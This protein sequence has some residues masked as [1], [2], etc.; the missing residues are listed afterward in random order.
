MGQGSHQSGQSSGGLLTSDNF[1]GTR[2]PVPEHELEEAQRTVEDAIA[3]QIRGAQSPHD[4]R[5]LG[6]VCYGLAME[7]DGAAERY[8][9]LQLAKDS[10]VDAGDCTRAMLAFDAIESRFDI[11]LFDERVSTVTKLVPTTHRPSAQVAVA[12]R[13]ETLIATAIERE[14]YTAAI[15]LS[16][17]GKRIAREFRNIAM[18]NKFELQSSQ[19]ALLQKAQQMV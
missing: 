18:T 9:L 16:A 17:S 12:D 2:I 8:V 10:F 15:D 11:D 14:E 1:S 19:A 7:S 4:R 5:H 3:S 13:V 6:T